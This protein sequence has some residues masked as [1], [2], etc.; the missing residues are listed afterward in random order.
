MSTISEEEFRKLCEDIYADRLLTYSFNPNASR[1]EA[2]LWMLLGCL[3]SLLSVPLSE[4][5]SA[6]GGSSVDPY[7]EAVCE[8]LKDRME[9][10]FDPQ[11]ILRELATRAE[12]EERGR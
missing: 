11:P 2:L 6:Y 9:P 8:V 5:P 7:G 10:P 1:R 3:L 12:A 4:Q